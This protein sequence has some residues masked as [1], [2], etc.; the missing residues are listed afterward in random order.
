MRVET[1]QIRVCACARVCV[2]WSKRTNRFGNEGFKVVPRVVS[3][4]LCHQCW[5]Q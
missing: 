3:G 1:S 5:R 2:T 4:D